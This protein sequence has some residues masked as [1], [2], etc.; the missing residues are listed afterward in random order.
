MKQRSEPFF[1]NFSV[2]FFLFEN[3]EFERATNNV[4]WK[5]DAVRNETYF[6]DLNDKLK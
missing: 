2:S 1:Q 5:F 3:F 4:K 6:C